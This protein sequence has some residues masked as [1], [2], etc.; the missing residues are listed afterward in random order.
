LFGTYLTLRTFKQRN[1]IGIQKTPSGLI[2][3]GAYKFARHPI[4]LGIILISGGFGLLFVN[5]DGIMIFPLIIMVNYLEGK[6]EEILDLNT[7]FGLDYQKYMDNVPILGP[8][9]IWTLI[10]SSTILFLII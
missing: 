1:A 10:I 2:V 7:R 3:S 8:I 9:W 4:Y 6:S 5:F